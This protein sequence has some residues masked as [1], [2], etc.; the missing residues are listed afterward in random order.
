MN[1]RG[2]RLAEIFSRIWAD[3]FGRAGLVLLTLIIGISILGPIIFPFDPR[4]VATSAS[5]IFAPPTAQHWLGTDEMGRDIFRS[6][7]AG[8]RIS[9]LV[10]ITAS[11]ISIVIGAF[12]GLFSGYYHGL[13]SNLLM[14]VTDFFLALPVTPLIIVLAS[15]FGQNLLITIMVIGMTSWPSTARIVR[16]LV[17]SI[18]ARQ[19]V[20]R[21][22]AIGAS[23]ARILCVHILPNVMPLIYANTVLVIAGSVLAE[24]TLAFLGLGD[25]VRVSW[26]TMLHYAFVSGAAGRGVWWYL[27]PPGIGIVLLVLGFTL[28]GNTLDKILNPR[29][30]EF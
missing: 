15:V 29:L 30:R 24:A 26:G 17:L 4:E 5:K 3:S 14:R 18:R 28:V 11:A 13:F 19:F 20:E 9:L 22:R 23:D 27:L 16:S 2:E 8:A 7:L 25:P 12:V 6:T 1:A 10:G 21:V